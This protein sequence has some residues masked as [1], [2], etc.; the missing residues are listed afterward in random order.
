MSVFHQKLSNGDLG[1][2]HILKNI[3]NSLIIKDRCILAHLNNA[4]D[5]ER[6]AHTAGRP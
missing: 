1:A 2:L 6:A 4:Q 5:E 3:N